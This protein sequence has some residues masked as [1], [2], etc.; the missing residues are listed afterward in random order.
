MATGAYQRL[1]N[2]ATSEGQNLDVSRTYIDGVNGWSITI[3][4]LDPV[5]FRAHETGKTIDAAAA[6]VIEELETVGVSIP[7]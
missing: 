2:W 4:I 3:S 5:S 1:L 7:S 6:K